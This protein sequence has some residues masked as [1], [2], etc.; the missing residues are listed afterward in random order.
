MHYLK[1]ENAIFKSG[2]RPIEAE[3]VE[4]ALLLTPL[5]QKRDLK[6]LGCSDDLR[7]L[8]GLEAAGRLIFIAVCRCIGHSE[9][10]SCRFTIR[11]PAIFS[12]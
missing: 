10:S 3:Q 1:Q 12:G 6:L 2:L 5:D 8:P 7:S 4:H 11:F 9:A